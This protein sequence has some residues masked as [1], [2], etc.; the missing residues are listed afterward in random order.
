MKKLIK[1]LHK[2]QTEVFP[3]KQNFFKELAKGQTPEIL[4]ISCSD[5]RINPN[6]VTSAEPGEMFII[7]NAGNIVPPYGTGGSE[8]ATIELAVNDLM[9]KDIILCG[10]SFCGAVHAT[11]EEEKYRN[12]P[13][14]HRW[15]ETYIKPT[16]SL[17]TENY[18]GMTHEEKM[19]VLTQEHILKQVENLKTH[20][21]VNAKL[22]DG[23][24]AVHAWM[25]SFE[26]GQILSYNIEDGQFEPISQ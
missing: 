4:F 16:L 22:L 20:P 3:L 18:Q 8:E 2:F 19:E 1:G 15:V 13:S 5:S 21:A 23:S 12:L 11:L 17:I 9:V 25:Y 6:M 10:H 7:R 14:L 26:T 24:L